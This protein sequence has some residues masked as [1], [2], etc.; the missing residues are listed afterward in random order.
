MQ[1]Q[2][3]KRGKSP[4]P[5]G[6]SAGDIITQKYI[7]VDLRSLVVVLKKAANQGHLEEILKNFEQVSKEQPD[8]TLL[9]PG[10][11]LDRLISQFAFLGLCTGVT[12]TATPT[13]TSGTVI[14]ASRSAGFTYSYTGSPPCALSVL[15]VR[16]TVGAIQMNTNTLSDSGAVWIGAI[17][18]AAGALTVRTAATIKATFSKST[19]GWCNTC[20]WGTTGSSASIAVTIT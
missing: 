4:D 8:M 3:K 17:P 5:S 14:A 15:Q 2:E 9:L 13:L 16:V 20:N 11:F 6:G 12:G 19:N 10:L 1:A 7:P 18:A